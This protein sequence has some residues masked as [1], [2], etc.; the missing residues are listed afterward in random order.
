MDCK[1]EIERRAQRSRATARRS[2]RGARLPA[3]LSNSDR[4]GVA[5]SATLGALRPRHDEDGGILGAIALELGLQG[6]LARDPVFARHPFCGVDL[7]ALAD[8]RDRP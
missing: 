2:P 8:A 1:A 3:G 7:G 4:P 5:R 6:A